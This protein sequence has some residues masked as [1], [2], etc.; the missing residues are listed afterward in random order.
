MIERLPHLLA[1]VLGLGL[2]RHE[3]SYRRVSRTLVALLVIDV[4]RGGLRLLRG[5]VAARLAAYAAGA[6]PPPYV[7]LA[8]V[9]WATELML[10]TAWYA[11]L[12]WVVWRSLGSEQASRSARLNYW[13]AAVGVVLAVSLYLAYPAVRGRPIEV[14][15]LIMFLTA[16][17]VQFFAVTRYVLRWKRPSY[18]A[19][20]ALILAIGSTADLVLWMRGHPV[21]D[22]S[23]GAP[24]G[25][26]IFA[27]VGGVE[28]WGIV[29]ARKSH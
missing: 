27:V 25:V 14:A 18:S 17:A 11:V 19:A 2:A 3:Q 22:W 12:T 21:R 29:A 28:L 13:P 10:A 16:L 9:S 8:R 23:S 15:S 1:A 24:T 20:V 26:L 7:G 5:D 6:V 4:A